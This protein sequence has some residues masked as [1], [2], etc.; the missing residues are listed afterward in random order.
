MRARGAFRASGY[1]GPRM[2]E[3]A[4]PTVLP[5]IPR[6]V[7][8]GVLWLFFAV[9]LVTHYGANSPYAYVVAVMDEST[10]RLSGFV[11]NG[12]AKKSV[13]SVFFFYDGSDVVYSE[14][15]N[16]KLPIHSLLVATAAAFLRSYTLAQYLVNLFSLCLLSYVAVRLAD[17]FRYPR[18]ATLIAALTCAALPLYTHYIGTPKQYVVGIAVNFLIVLAAVA[19]AR[20]GVRDP[21]RH[22]LLMA[23]LTL[24]YDPVVFAA[25][26]LCWVVVTMRWRRVREYAVY[27]AAAFGPLLV[28]RGFLYAISAGT[29]SDE[30]GEDFFEP[31]FRAWKNFFLDPRDHA[32]MPFRDGYYGIVSS[33]HMLLGLVYW[34]VVAACV[35]GLFVTR[36]RLREFSGNTLMLL[37]A[38]MFVLEQMVAGQYVWENQPRRAIPLVLAVSYAYFHVVRE[39]IGLQAWRIAFTVIAIL[40][41]FLTF[42]DTL[43]RT[44]L[45][46]YLATDVAVN[47]PAKDLVLYDTYMSPETYPKLVKDENPR[48]W[49]M[50]R[51]RVTRP[52]RFLF[53][54]VFVAAFVVVLLQ[55]L[56]ERALVP[57]LLPAGFAVAFLL[58]LGARLI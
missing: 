32:L 28:W 24:S 6:W 3:A 27:L 16:L 55:L 57:R 20:D 42:A 34:P 29:V 36:A 39:K 4:P 11:V 37:V 56:R 19:C 1:H 17:S 2:D 8:V 53:A 22:G 51:A 46:A 49:D 14:A 50:A 12:D 41:L 9:A 15:Y 21:L 45:I 30:I 10:A 44:P 48:W 13:S 54:N 26:L 33:V 58:S 38:L 40:S 7:V 18:S 5:S 25:G 47:G 52:V 31:V 23:V 35:A 43:R